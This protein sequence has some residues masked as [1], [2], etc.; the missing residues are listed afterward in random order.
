MGLFDSGIVGSAVKSGIGGVVMGP[1]GAL[2]ATQLGDDPSQWLNDAGGLMGIGGGGS[3]QISPY[4]TRD[5]TYGGTGNAYGRDRMFADS[6]APIQADYSMADQD[7]ATGA[8]DRQRQMDNLARVEAM[9]RGEGVSVAELQR[10]AGQEQAMQ[11]SANLAA[12]ARG[13]GAAQLVAQRQAQQAQMMG[14]QS[15]GRD[16]AMLRADEMQKANAMALQGASQLRGQGQADRGMSM[17]Q[18]SE[19]G[20]LALA[21]RGQNDA[22]SMG[23]LQAQIAEEQNKAQAQ[24]GNADRAAGAAGAAMGANAQAAAAKKMADAQQRA[25][26]MGAGATLGAA[27]LGGK[28]CPSSRWG[29]TRT[30]A[31]SIRT[32]GLCRP[33]R[34]RLCLRLVTLRRV[35][36]SPRCQGRPPRPLRLPS[37]RLARSRRCSSRHPLAVPPRNSGTGQ[38]RP[39]STAMRG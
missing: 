19:Q 25:A 16:A 28:L 20:K 27:S 9:A 12:S 10:Q 21:G 14:A 35:E 37:S 6:R 26:I 13:G 11:Q 18:A 29:P 36:I 5:T 30:G 39:P 1:A 15:A 7:R 38:A 17:Q 22:R 24:A 2:G 31:R 8:G 3:D 32:T 4:A 33:P 34:L 23:L